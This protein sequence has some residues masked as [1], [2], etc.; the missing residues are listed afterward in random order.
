MSTQNDTVAAGAGAR[1]LASL[2]PATDSAP[3]AEVA[4]KFS[5]FWASTQAG[6]SL[7]QQLRAKKA[8]GNPYALEE[9]IS[10]FGIDEKSTAYPQEK[11]SPFAADAGEFADVLRAR[12]ALEEEKRRVARA[13][14]R[15]AIVFKSGGLLPAAA[16]GGGGGGGVAAAPP[17]GASR[18]TRFG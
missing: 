4:S 9:V 15:A 13:E 11:W 12:Q 5:H 7:V 6:A 2:P 3:V 1:L 18:T 10:T 16:G 8:F 17:P 14:P